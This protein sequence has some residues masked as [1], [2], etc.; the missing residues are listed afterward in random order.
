[1]KGQRTSKRRAGACLLVCV[2]VFLGFGIAQAKSLYVI[3]SINDDP[4]P[5]KTFDIQG[6]PNYLVYQATQGVPAWD[7]GAVGLAID[8]TNKK[9]FVTY[10]CS[11]KI[12]LLDATN[13]QDLGYTTAPGASDLAGIAVDE[14]KSRVY[15]VDRWTPTLYVYDWDGVNNI[16]TLVSGA[17]FT[18]ANVSESFG[19]A[20]DETRKRLYV[21]DYS[22]TTVRYFNTDTW[23][24]AGNFTLSLSNQPPIGIAVDSVRNLVYTGMAW[25][26][27]N[28][29]VKYDLNTN[30]ETFYT[31]SDPNEGAMGI[32]VDEDTGY[33]YTST[34]YNGDRLLVF[35]SNLNLIHDAGVLGDAPTGIAIPRAQVSYNPLNF[36]KTGPSHIT[37]TM[38]YNLC[39]D[40][41]NN[42]FEVTGVTITDTLPPELSFLSATGGGI[43]SG[44]TVTWN[45]GNLAAHAPQACVTLTTQ[46]VTSAETIIN[47]ATI[48]SDQTPPTTQGAV[49][50]RGAHAPKTGEI[51]MFQDGG[52]RMHFMTTY[53]DDLGNGHI[54]AF[55][56]HLQSNAVAN[57][58]PSTRDNRLL[59]L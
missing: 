44:G 23:A 24:E 21:A 26:E 2:A 40:N 54:R 16:L 55:T 53:H 58:L 4:T 13:F 38:T 42:N 47:Y 28:K 32:A 8:T 20:L 22:S 17:P 46:T 37:P 56:G 34:G 14:G 12:Q 45:I 3:G 1:M 52:R 36:S 50:E 59:I 48:D 49:T 10:E 30:T 18:L 11:D 6:P 15:A 29:L 5:I 51:V 7:C 41:V 9:L 39:Y 35:D 27:G 31:F 57:P 19:I 33:V 43:Y 25:D